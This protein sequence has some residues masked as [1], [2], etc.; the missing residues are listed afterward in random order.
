MI[1]NITILALPSKRIQSGYYVNSLSYA[2]TDTS[3]TSLPIRINSFTLGT[4]HIIRGDDSVPD[5]SVIFSRDSF[6]SHQLWQSLYNSADCS[7]TSM[8]S[9]MGTLLDT[10]VCTFNK[11]LNYYQKHNF[12]VAKLPAMNLLANIQYIII[13]NAA[14]VL[15][16][17][18]STWYIFA[19]A[20]MML[21]FSVFRIHFR[22][23][24]LPI[25]W[26]KYWTKFC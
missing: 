7:G 3:C 26:E 5:S 25:R 20:V 13:F 14:I 11:K 21:L 22:G 17:F 24:L 4:C 18:I 12:Y 16:A 19:F 6:D 2:A 23:K 8:E 10:P 1:Y 9:I 15:S